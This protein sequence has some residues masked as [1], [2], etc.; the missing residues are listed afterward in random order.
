MDR[1]GDDLELDLNARRARGVREPHRVVVERLPVGCVHLE[2][3][4]VAQVGARRGDQRL[5]RVAGVDVGG[6]ERS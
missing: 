4:Q 2:R 3:R 6:G 1:V 5:S